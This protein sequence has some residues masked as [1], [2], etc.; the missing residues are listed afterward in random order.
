M[1]IPKIKITDP[2]K[3]LV[4]DRIVRAAAEYYG[5]EIIRD[6]SGQADVHF[7]LFDAAQENLELSNLR[8]ST[9]FI[10]YRKVSHSEKK[11]SITF[12]EDESSVAPVFHGRTLTEKDVECIDISSFEQFDTIVAHNENVPVWKKTVKDMIDVHV[13]ST[14][15]SEKYHNLPVYQILRRERFFTALAV[16][17]FIRMHCHE[18]IWHYPQLRASLTV[19]DPNLHSMDY[20]YLS[21]NTLV[22]QLKYLD[23]HA[24]I[25]TVPFDLLFYQNKKVIDF[26]KKNSRY[27]SLCAHGLFHLKGD[28]KNN[29]HTSLSPAA[30]LKWADMVMRRFENKTGLM[31]SRLFIPPHERL[32]ID[33]LIA[34]QSIKC[35]GF[36]LGGKPNG[37]TTDIDPDEIT[38]GITPATWS[39][40]IPIYLRE[41]LAIFSKSAP[42]VGIQQDLLLQAFLNKPLFLCCHHNDFRDGYQTMQKAVNY[43]NSIEDVIW[44]DTDKI[45]QNNFAFRR[46]GSCLDIKLF[47]TN[48]KISVPDWCQS[49]RILNRSAND[50][51]VISGEIV[52]CPTEEFEFPLN[53]HRDISI[54]QILKNREITKNTISPMLFLQAFV[55]RIACEGRDR[56]LPISRK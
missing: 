19:D 13:I 28:L 12:I 45:C 50:I 30:Y 2:F 7:V 49:V 26:V 46:N 9:L 48:A 38:T 17:N 6:I 40:E 24:T 14:L 5:A 3:S 1:N 47:T 23:G 41:N 36:C 10:P 25:A 21:Y 20:G 53:D 16:F 29:K 18:S 4:F 35:L 11:I 42:D 32:G 55:R 44:S 33:F 34:A 52:C 43:I 31:I 15:L 56:L 37:I 54:I 22:E 39:Y 27:V 8:S 51:S